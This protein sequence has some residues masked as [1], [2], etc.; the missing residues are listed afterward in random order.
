MYIGEQLIAPTDARLRLSA[1]LGARGIVIDTRPAHEVIEA[2]GTW[3]SEKVAALRRRIE[4]FG[5]R[6]DGMALDVGSLLLDSLRAPDK[7]KETAARL[8]QHIRAAAEGG[9]TMLKYTV[10]M[11][12]I[13]RT[14]VVE[15]RG[16]MQC[17]TFRAADYRPEADARF[18]YWG[19]VLPED[20]SGGASPVDQHGAP[21]TCGQVLAGTAGAISEADG[22]RSIAFLVSELLPT[23]EQVGV[24]LACHPHDPAYPPGG[25]NGVHHVLGSLDGMRR[26]VAL[27]PDSPC[28]G[29]NF[30]QGTIAE[31]STD[32]TATVL[33]AIRTF[34]PQKR[35]FMVHFRN[36]TGG[37]LDFREAMPDE[38]TVDM[39]ACIRAYRE[40]GYEGILCPDHVPLSDLDPGRER[41]FAFALGYTKA[42]LQAA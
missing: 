27:A 23:A 11:V 38:G 9:V 26:F 8:R 41:F 18:S 29:F 35:I 2:D 5:M 19:T 30:C 37:Y 36:I 14:G 22:W 16:G 7:A 12:G 34:G 40:V 1:Q 10:A 13:T 31:M 25:L 20:G 39:A 4:G 21:E 17:S 3:N 32:P 42:L 33:E 28:H 24:K 15:G 6:L